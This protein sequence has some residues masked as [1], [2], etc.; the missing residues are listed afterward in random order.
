MLRATST[1]LSRFPQR[2]SLALAHP[3]FTAY[4]PKFIRDVSGIHLLF[5]FFRLFPPPIHNYPMQ[6][7]NSASQ[8]SGDVV[9]AVAK[10]TE[11]GMYREARSAEFEAEAA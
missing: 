3:L 1:F 4:A 10:K 11:V 8:P 6:I 7:H 9:G 5:S 2:A